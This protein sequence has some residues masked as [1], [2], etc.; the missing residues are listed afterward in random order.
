MLVLDFTGMCLKVV[1][2]QGF[3]MNF[4][5]QIGQKCIHYL[6]S[7][8]LYY[9]LHG[10]SYMLLGDPSFPVPVLG[11]KRDSRYYKV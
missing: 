4:R 8:L 2:F 6:A 1:G 3:L 10:I 7:R 9:F 5:L 11:T